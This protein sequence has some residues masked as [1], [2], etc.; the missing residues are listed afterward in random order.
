MLLEDLPLAPVPL[1]LVLDQ[2]AADVLPYCK[3][4]SSP[5]FL[6]FGDTGDDVAALCGALLALFTQ[7]NLINQ[8]FDSP[9]ATFVRSRICISSRRR[10]PTAST[11]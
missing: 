1:H 6:G 5:F 8:S 4:E 10:R 7:Q 2:F 9:S 3:N 11:P